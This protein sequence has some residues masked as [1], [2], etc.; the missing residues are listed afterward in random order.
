M[1]TVLSTDQDM[2]S[3]YDLLPLPVSRAVADFSFQSTLSASC[4]KPIGT[5]LIRE[6]VPS[7]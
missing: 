2:L 1:D 5:F 6:Q 4:Q 3:I 7:F